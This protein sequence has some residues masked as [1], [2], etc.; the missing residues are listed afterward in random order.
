MNVNRSAFA[1]L[2]LVVVFAARAPAATDAPSPGRIIQLYRQGKVDAARSV[3]MKLVLSRIETAALAKQRGPDAAADKATW[4]RTLNV[5]CWSLGLEVK[6]GAFPPPALFKLCDD[7]VA[8]CDRS[9]DDA[10]KWLADSGVRACAAA[11]VQ[12]KANLLLG[13]IVVLRNAGKAGRAKGLADRHQGFLKSFK[14]P[15][16]ELLSNKALRCIVWQGDDEHHFYLEKKFTDDTKDKRIGVDLKMFRLPKT[17][18][19]TPPSGGAND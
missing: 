6:Q 7:A 1:A 10:K 19:H 5:L 13:Q 9:L 11:S 3:L 14:V 16:A 4:Y 17:Q 2:L 12:S 8:A 18:G 15:I